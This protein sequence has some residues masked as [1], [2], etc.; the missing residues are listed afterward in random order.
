MIH[1]ANWLI[2]ALLLGLGGLA[3]VSLLEDNRQ[4]PR[5]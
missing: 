1:D 5:S 4:G 3:Y 2:V